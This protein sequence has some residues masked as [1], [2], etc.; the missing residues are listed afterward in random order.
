MLVLNIL[1]LLYRH[2]DQDHRLTQQQIVELLASEYQMKAERKSIKRNLD[3]LTAAGY[4]IEH[5]TST[6]H[7]KNGELED[8]ATDWYFN[9]DFDDSELRLL[10]DSL[11][12]SRQIP[13]SQ[14]RQLINK[15]K[16]LSSRYFEAHVKHVQSL[17]EIKSPNNQLF[18]T[19]SVLD[20]AI[21]KGRRVIFNYGSFTT[22]GKL[23][24]RQDSQGQ[25][26][27]YRIDPYQLVATNG[28][29]YL[30]CRLDPH[31]TLSYYRVDRIL[32]IELCDEP[33]KA[34]RE[35]P[36]LDSGLD[37][38]QHMAEHIY[39]FSGSAVRTRLRVKRT[40]LSHIFD[41]FGNG[42]RFENEGED[43]VEVVLRANEQ[44]MRY[45][46]LQ[47]YEHVEV[48][49]PPSLRKSLQAAGREIARRYKG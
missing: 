32:N 16:Q 25:P 5:T 11:L 44:A 15:L 31:D 22:S 37:L 39:M 23:L 35:L 28:R 47:F 48:L 42:V 38:P 29:Y 13:T 34:L 43:S 7:N 20:E 17:P 27:V 3:E 2:T 8:I 4:G 6:R 30:I 12:F 46:A 18:Y 1:N 26:R 40:A 49:E 36:G 24:A 9:H 10:I 19:V 45:W 33:V 41:W 14:C 21:E